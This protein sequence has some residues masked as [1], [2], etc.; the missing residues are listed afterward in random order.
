MEFGEGELIRTDIGE[1]TREQAAGETAE[2]SADRKRVNLG[3]EHVDAVDARCKFVVAH[4][5]HGAAD[6]GI[7]QMP[8][9][10]ADDRQHRDAERQIALRGLEQLGTADVGDAVGTMRDADR[11]DHDQGHDL[12]ER[13]RHHGE[14]MTAEPQGRRAEKGARHQRNAAAHHKAEP[15]AHVEIGG[16]EPDGIGTKAEERRLRQVDLAAKTQHDAKPE[17]GDRERGRLQ[18][19]V[20]DVAVE[21]HACCERDQ[22]GSGDKIRHMAD[23]DEPRAQ[24][25][26]RCLHV[27]A[28]NAHA[29]SATRSP[30][31]PCGR[32]I[33][34]AIS[35]RKAKPSL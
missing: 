26:R 13:D 24:D 16:A 21:T 23:Q 22:D 33:R 19:D 2:H 32:K 10:V 28:P 15:V 11:I 14:V 9:Q 7:R 6:P 30:N 27:V 12:L 29:F 5:T 17:H 20:E 35:T 31:S 3:P 25:R 4:R 8:D 18:Q 1:A 34:K